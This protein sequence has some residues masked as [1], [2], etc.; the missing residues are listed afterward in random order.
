M[1]TSLTVS[2]KFT[3]ERAGSHGLV[4]VFFTLGLHTFL[5]R[6]VIYVRILP[7]KLLSHNLSNLFI[8]DHTR[9]LCSPW[10]FGLTHPLF[11]YEIVAKKWAALIRVN[12]D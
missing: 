6:F 2:P 12:L 3:M 4:I 1:E 9:Q 5:I 11:A 10:L 7:L 8:F